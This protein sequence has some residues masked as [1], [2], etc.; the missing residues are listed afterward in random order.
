VHLAQL[1]LGWAPFS[2]SGAP[3]VMT[4]IVARLGPLPQ[5]WKGLYN[6]GEGEDLWYDQHQPQVRADPLHSF[7]DSL[8]PEMG[9]VERDI[10][11]LVLGRGFCYFPESRLSAAQL[12]EDVS[13]RT[14]LSLYGQ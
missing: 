11:C 6:A 2:G 1:I 12:I 10:T 4:S 5:H 7:I 9:R 14:L 3:T 8:R 13:F